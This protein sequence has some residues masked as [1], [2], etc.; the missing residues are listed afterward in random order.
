MTAVNLLAPDFHAHLYS[1]YA[2]LRGGPVRQVAP[3]GMWVISRY[4]DALVALKDPRFSSAG[5]ARMAEPP[6][7]GTTPFSGAMVTMDPPRHT[8][9]RALVSRAFGATSMARLES[10]VRR[11][12][13]E[14][15]EDLVRRREVEFV[16]DFAVPLPGEVIG[17]LLGLERSVFPKFKRWATALAM[18]TAAHTP[19][20]QEEV[21]SALK[22]LELYLRE[23]IASRHQQPREDMVSELLRAEV[24]GRSLSDEEILS[25]MFLLLPAGLETT[26]N[27][28]ANTMICLA[29]HPQEL[30]RARAQPDSIPR[31]IEE[32]L[33]FESPV[34]PVVRVT[35][36]EVE[37][38]GATI[39]AGA[40]VSILI[41]AANRDESRFPNADRFQPERPKESH[42]AFGHGTHFCLG[43]QLA[44][45]EARLALEALLP[46]IEGIRLRESG[47]RWLPGFMV[48]GPQEL[49][50]E[51]IPSSP[52]VP[53]GGPL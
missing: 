40:M 34:Q 29:N 53:H 41:A 3:G 38:G 24:D 32:V 19:E 21:R 51:L 28:L 5:L 33:R 15:A 45:M 16:H 14:L 43:A 44:R 10:L 13:Q 42:L 46:R 30:A 17:H 26:T 52:P 48:R 2:E 1:V 18:V 4:E 27:L 39:P 12:C 37:L 25:F 22:E 7:L 11:V 49:P 6:Y 36:A 31:L 23:V 20:M 35:T 9:M 8:R 47:V 50:L